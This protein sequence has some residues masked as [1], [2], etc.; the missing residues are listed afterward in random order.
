MEGMGFRSAKSVRLDREPIPLALN[1]SR[2]NRAIICRGLTSRITK[3]GEKVLRG[4][5]RY[6]F[7]TFSIGM[8]LPSGVQE[9]EDR[10][11]SDL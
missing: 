9:R 8:I 7:K 2:A 11:R 6:Q 1:W 5:K 4:A 10:L 3:V